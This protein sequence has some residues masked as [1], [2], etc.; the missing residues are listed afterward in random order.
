MQSRFQGKACYSGQKKGNFIRIKESNSLSYHK[1]LKTHASSSRISKYMKK[2]I[3]IDFNIFISKIDGTS[4]QNIRKD[5][6]ESNQ[7]YLINIYRTFHPT[8]LS[9]AHES[10]KRTDHI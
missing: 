1:I 8:F 5:A 7:L 4:R 3:D 9:S 10:F 6:K 2:K